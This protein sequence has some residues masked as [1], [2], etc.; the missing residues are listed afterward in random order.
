LYFLFVCPYDDLNLKEHPNT[1]AETNRL[2]NWDV[3]E[4]FI[5]SDF[6]N[7]RRY[8]EFEVSPQGEWV[9]LDIDMSQPHKED[10]W[11]WNSGMTVAARIDP[12]AKVWYAA[13][14]IPYA[15]VDSRPAK[16]GNLLRVNRV[17][18]SARTEIAWQATGQDNFH[19]PESFAI[20]RLAAHQ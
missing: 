1:A 6:H 18:G 12:A 3:A 7:I 5:G 8:K 14:R 9:D 16:E 15:A 17:Q 4:A 2:W 20:L 11:T 19:V 13:M 10:G